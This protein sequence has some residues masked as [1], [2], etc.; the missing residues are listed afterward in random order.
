MP[1]STVKYRFELKMLGWAVHLSEVMSG[2]NRCFLMVIDPGGAVRELLLGEDEYY[3][4]TEVWVKHME[5]RC[6]WLFYHPFDSPEYMYMQWKGIERSTVERLMGLQ[7]EETDF[8]QGFLAAS[9]N[10]SERVE[11]PT[12]WSVMF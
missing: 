3:Y 8:Y 7:F 12:S 10:E 2:E 5:S 1:R 6:C 9:A 4:D 11:F